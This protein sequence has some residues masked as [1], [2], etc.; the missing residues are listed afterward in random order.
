MKRAL[1]AALAVTVLAGGLSACVTATPY[2]Q[3][4]P[5]DREAGGY[6]DV[7]LDADH[8]RVTFSGN[9]VTSR[10]TVE[11]YLLYRAAELT[12]S[13]GGDWFEETQ[14]GTDRKT[15]VYVDPYYGGWGYGY[16]WRPAWRF[17]HGGFYGGW[18]TWGPGWAYDPWGPVSSFDRYEASAEIAIGK[19]PKPDAKALDA[20]EVMMNLG[21]GIVRP[22]A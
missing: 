21:P 15:D 20:H 6:G 12:L 22:K 4:N 3:I 19:G 8:W 9:T 11:R 5:K 13:Q 18:A 10:E 17:R 2:Q 1:M 7:R 14:Q 16:G